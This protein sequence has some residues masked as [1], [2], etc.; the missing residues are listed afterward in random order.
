MIVH[1]GCMARRID[2][3]WRAVLITGASGSGKSD[4]AL[5]LLDRGWRLVADDRTLLWRSDGRLWGR[6]P[7]T[8]HDLLELRGLHVGVA[9]ALPWAPVALE[10]ACAPPLERMPDR[11][12]RDRLGVSLPRVRIAPLE[13]SSPSR[14][15][16]ALQAALTQGLDP[17]SPGRI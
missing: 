7:D 14:V 12:L 13:A 17:P 5:R 15:E 9:P 10:V 1:A 8:L 16:R 3:R 11:D 4:L 6:A 2:G